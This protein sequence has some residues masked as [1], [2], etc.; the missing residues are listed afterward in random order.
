[1][2]TRRLRIIA[3]L[4]F[5]TLTLTAP[6]YLLVRRAA[7]SPAP[8]QRP[9][10]HYVG[11]TVC[12]TCHET[13][14]ADWRESDHALAMQIANEQ[15]VLGDF[16]NARFTYAEVSSIFYRRDGKFFVRTDGPD[17]Q[18]HDY[19]I[20][21][22]LGVR[23][24][25][26]YLIAFPDGRLQALSIAWDTRP[27]SEG[28][29][30]WFHL[31]PDQRI[32]HRDPLHWTGRNQTWNYMCAACH[33]TNLQK[34]YDLASDRYATTW[35]E[36][37]VSCE[38][39]HGPGSAHLAWAKAQ[40]SGY[41]SQ[42]DETKGLSVGL[43]SSGGHWEISDPAGPAARWSG[44]P[45][46][47]LEIET[48][49]VCHAR[50]QAI[51]D[52]YQFGRPFLDAYMPALLERGLY[53]A[54]G[55]ILDEV[56]EY[57]SFTQSKMHRA[58][59]TC[60]DCHNPHSLKLRRGTGNATCNQCHQPSKFDT[61][62]HHHHKPGT[63]AA[64]C[65]S[66]HMPKKNYM[67]VDVRRD[68]SFRLP[69]PD[70]SVA[71]G[72]PN[73]CTQCHTGKSAQWAAEAVRRW[74]GPARRS[75][76]HF[77]A[78][79]EA[80]RRS[81]IG[82]EKSL[83]SLA[84]DRQ[85][86]PIVRATALSLLPDYLTPASMPAIVAGLKDEEPLLRAVAART[87][88]ALPPQQRLSLLGP[89]LHDPVRAVRI[90]AARALAGTPLELMSAQQRVALEQS[91]AEAVAAELAAAERPESHFNLSLLYTR[92]ARWPEAEAALQTAL[93]LDPRFVPALVNLADLYRIAGRDSEGEKLLRQAISIAPESAEAIHALGLLMVRQGRRQEATKLLRRAA[94]LRPEVAR[95]SHA[96]A[97]ALQSS[98]EQAGA[99]A[100]LEQAHKRHPAEREILL[101][102]IAMERERG[103]LH[104]AITYAEKL[105]R[106]LPGEPAA[107][108]LLEQLRQAS[109]S[110]P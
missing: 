64:Q 32:T 86:P 103:R 93:R 29:Q 3:F 56:Y 40:Q 83:S 11:Q 39:C 87:T 76:Q 4:L 51:T 101:A 65:I 41:K 106:L 80:G 13:E 6:V 61:S 107:R 26:Q 74:Y 53:Q 27:A 88:E 45:R 95:Y 42:D 79:I 84:T 49:A 91:L 105:A 92:L 69:R 62:E 102:L 57:G 70:L 100:V 1:M 97:L 75:E 35:S 33:S 63:E 43:R 94:T 28:G 77:V 24:L 55:Q 20:A 81:L 25:Q 78:A 7:R 71:Y 21:Y 110:S 72:T 90:E 89:L 30:R 73:A 18:L 50:R 98:G 2:R 17:G 44:P 5:V 48:C 109:S 34:N 31:Y 16:N 9:T 60:S 108:A 59:V 68:H 10:Q 46:S 15:T 14:A 23:P 22:T 66:C 85:W 36:I 99:I 96:Y 19:E 54:D 52:K 67:V 38:A 37:N 12:A 82:A 47:Q 58:G 8:E 104:S